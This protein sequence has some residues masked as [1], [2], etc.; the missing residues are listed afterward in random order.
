MRDVDWPMA[1]PFFFCDLDNVI[2]SV[3]VAKETKEKR[4]FV[5]YH[6]QV[7]WPLLFIV[8]FLFRL[9]LMLYNRQI[10]HGLRDVIVFVTKLRPIFV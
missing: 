8:N 4:L 6:R 10:V 1:V 9:F 7:S 3:C 5:G 2:L